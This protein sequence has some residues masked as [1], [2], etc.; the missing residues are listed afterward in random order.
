MYTVCTRRACPVKGRPIPFGEP[1]QVW[2]PVQGHFSSQSARLVLPT[3]RP[4][5]KQSLLKETTLSKGDLVSFITCPQIF[6]SHFYLPD[7]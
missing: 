3:L 7:V 4:Q 1:L 2:L 6:I 5:L